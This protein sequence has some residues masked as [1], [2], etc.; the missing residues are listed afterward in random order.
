MCHI[1]D[2][3]GLEERDVKAQSSKGM[4]PSLL[5]TWSL[6]ARGC[7]MGCLPPQAQLERSLEEAQ[8]EAERMEQALQELE[9]RAQSI[10]VR[11]QPPQ[12]WAG[13]EQSEPHSLPSLQDSSERLQAVI[14]SKFTH[15]EEALAKFREQ[16]VAKVKQ[17]ESVAMG[18]IEKNRNA[19]KDHL[20]ALG[21]HRDQAQH[22]MDC[23][24]HQTFLKVPLV[25]PKSHP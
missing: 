19:L 12:G 10:E 21:Q 13:W 7:S 1:C 8:R 3:F 9:E 6:G 4:Q 24:D 15:L 16:M 23:T 5:L 20:E 22:L 11:P 25:H 17:E 14:L 2:P 18:H